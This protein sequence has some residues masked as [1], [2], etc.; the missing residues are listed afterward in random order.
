MQPVRSRLDDHPRR[1]VPVNEFTGESQQVHT[2][3]KDT[4][5]RPYLSEAQLKLSVTMST[6]CRQTHREDTSP[7]FDERQTRNAV[8][9][10]VDTNL[11]NE[12][13]QRDFGDLGQPL[14]MEHS[15]RLVTDDGLSDQT[16][17]AQQWFAL[18]NK[19]RT[20]VH[21]DILTGEEQ[22][23]GSLFRLC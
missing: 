9:N 17:T 11:G 21:S 23:V 22:R 10:R 4:G 20:S 8:V 3:D 15:T 16:S 2:H 18:S 1:I 13:L 7:A 6:D 14:D 19:E 12:E 5:G